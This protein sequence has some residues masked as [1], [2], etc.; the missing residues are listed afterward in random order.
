MAT[1]QA[2]NLRLL[3]EVAAAGRTLQDVNDFLTNEL[4]AQALT[5]NMLERKVGVGGLGYEGVYYVCA[6]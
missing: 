2:D 1:L 4:R 3:R 6:T 5:V